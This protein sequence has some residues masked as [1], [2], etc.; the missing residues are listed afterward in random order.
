MTST[1]AKQIADFGPEI[2]AG[3]KFSLEE[4]R[5][6]CRELALSHYENFTVA[7]WLLPKRLRQHFCNVYAFCRWADNL[8]DEAGNPARCLQLL[9]WWEQ[10]LEACYQDMPSHPIMIALH[11]TIEQFTIP[12]ELFRRLIRAFRSDQTI[13]RYQT[14]ADLLSYCRD[15]ANPVGEIVLYLGECHSPD[16]VQWSNHLCTGLQLAN[17]AQDVARDYAIGRIYLPAEFFSEGFVLADWPHPLRDIA[18]ISNAVRNLTQAAEEQF[19]YSEPLIEN[20]SESI[21]LS[22]A[23]FLAGGRATLDAIRRQDY[24]VCESRPTLSRGKKMQIFAGCWWRTR[25]RAKRTSSS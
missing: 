12:R 11:D 21:R 9:D 14:L 20:V 8:G 4:S 15:S 3:R 24:A 23:M 13:T 2:A 17:F 18:S 25:S 19:R 7:S 10:K 16:Y 1:W 5:A 22:V 6:I